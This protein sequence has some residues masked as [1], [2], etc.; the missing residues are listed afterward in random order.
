[1]FKSKWRVATTCFLGLLLLAGGT[2]CAQQ[3]DQAPEDQKAAQ[4]VCQLVHRFHISQ[5]KIDDDISRKTLKRYI[6]SVDPLKLYFIKKDIEGFKKF[7]TKLDDQLLKGDV[8][9]AFAVHQGYLERVRRQA[10]LAATYIKAEH[11][12]TVDEARIANPK[13][14]DWCS[15]T[16]ELNERWRKR[17]KAELLAK[18][19]DDTKLPEARQQLSKRY[20]N[21]LRFAEQT[22]RSEVLQRY[23]SSMTHSFDPHSSYMSPQTREDFDISMRLRLQG[24]GAALSS[25][26]GFTVVR[27]IVPG[28]AADKDGRL[29]LGDKIIGVGQQEGDIEDIVEMKLSRVVRLIRGKKDTKVRLQV[30]TAKTSETKVY[31]LTR[32]IIELKQSAVT[33]V[34][35][36]A[37]KRIA[38]TSGRIGVINM[39]SFYRDFD[40]ERRGVADFRS[41]A[42]DVRKALEAFN[43]DGKVDAVILDLRTNGGGALK[44][45]V[46]VS[47]L[48]IDEGPVVRVKELDGTITPHEDPDPSISWKGPLVVMTSRMSASASEIFAG[49]I[50]D[51][52]RGLLVGDQTTHGKGT[53]QN[54]MAVRTSSP[55]NFFDRKPPGALKLTIQQFYRVNGE[56]SQERG[57][58]SDIILPSVINHMDIGENALENHLPFDKIAAAN[59]DAVSLVNP[60]IVAALAASSK[61]RIDA[62]ADFTKDREAIKKFLERKKR[63]TVSLN[64]AVL[65]KEIEENKQ[66]DELAVPGTLDKS[67]KDDTDKP[68]TPPVFRDDHYSNEVLQITL[69]YI[70]QLK[71][72]DLVGK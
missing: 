41:S 9:F 15:S 28:G 55:L 42:R 24:I 14:L 52:R 20:I 69:D 8:K 49:A 37:G 33:S 45:S 2:I 66:D 21:V 6:E 1:M 58:P 29:Q 22:D 34:I 51:Y 70:R 67:D 48:F 19:L 72:A 61:K 38:G 39:P 47:G 7:E 62:N 3:F 30:K 35:I 43:A 16:K 60:K 5:K 59:Y 25:E 68:K 56:S 50:A 26:D 27:S 71:Q 44:D 57:I 46:E 23:L 63:K 18:I 4:M 54:V 36:D 12:F 40:A 13:F 31:E 64:E 11:D 10:K 65:R 17:I 32:Q 53:V